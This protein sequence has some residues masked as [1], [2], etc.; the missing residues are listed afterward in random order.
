[1]KEKIK[2][3][4]SNA[5]K[6]VLGFTTLAV[7][8][9]LTSVTAFAA[10]ETS[11]VAVIK[12]ALTTGLNDTKTTFMSILAVVVVAAMGFFAIKY[13]INQGIGFFSKVSKKG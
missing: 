10:E 12:G 9:L 13:A 8:P 5:K 7:F 2:N 6:K 1:M 11:D 3:L 4:S